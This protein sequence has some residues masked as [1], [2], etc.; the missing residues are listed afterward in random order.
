M[1]A[2]SKFMKIRWR[3]YFTNVFMRV[4]NNLARSLILSE[5]LLLLSLHYQRIGSKQHYPLACHFVCRTWWYKLLLILSFYISHLSYI[6]SSI[7]YDA[8]IF[9][10]VGSWE[11]FKILLY[12]FV[13]IRNLVSLPFTGKV[14]KSTTTHQNFFLLCNTAF[15]TKKT[16]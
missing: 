9:S 15:K 3:T 2:S 10:F 5:S 12:K 14:A 1:L 8:N 6:F 13:L 4:I 16:K 11:H 7:R